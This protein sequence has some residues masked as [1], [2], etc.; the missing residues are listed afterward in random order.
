M[1]NFDEEEKKDQEYRKELVELKKVR[2]GK[3]PNIFAQ[4]REAE[5]AA[6]KAPV[7]FGQKLSNFWY[8]YRGVVAVVVILFG[9]AGFF[10]WDVLSRPEYDLTTYLSASYPMSIMQEPFEKVLPQY[11]GD[12]NKDGKVLV[13]AGAAT[14]KAEGER[15]DKQF[16]TAN[17]M[18]VMGALMNGDPILFFVDDVSY[19]YMFDGQYFVDLTQYVEAGGKNTAQVKGKRFYL[20][21]TELGKELA[22]AAEISEEDFPE[23]LSL[24]FRDTTDLD[25]KNDEVKKAYEYT[26]TVVKNLINGKKTA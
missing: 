11:A 26:E 7:T 13:G 10:L 15:V 23:D 20:K 16:Q 9:V 4:E 21:G 5:A 22:K 12:L 6:P 17:Q 14:I 25:M 18:K 3:A 24:V 1:S 2:Q 19:E 8:H